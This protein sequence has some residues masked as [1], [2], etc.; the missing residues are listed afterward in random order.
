MQKRL[1]GLFSSKLLPQSNAIDTFL[2]FFFMLACL[3]ASGLINGWLLSSVASTSS[4]FKYLGR[5]IYLSSLL[6]LPILLSHRFSQIYGVTLYLGVAAFTAANWLHVFFYNAPLSAYVI[7]VLKETYIGEVYEFSREFFSAGLFIRITL[8]FLAP[9]PFLVLSLRRKQRSLTAGL[10]V[11]LAVCAFIAPRA[12]DKSIPTLIR[13]NYMA[14]FAISC[15]KTWQDAE[16]F[17][18]ALNAPVTL[19]QNITKEGTPGRIIVLVMGESSSRKH[20]SLYGYPRPTTPRLDALKSEFFVFSDVISPN[21]HTVPVLRKIFTFTE[22]ENTTCQ[23]PL[24]PTLKAG[25]YRVVVLSN[26]PFLGEYETETSKLLSLADQVRYFNIGHSGSKYSPANPDG[27]LLAPF[28]QNLAYQDDLFVI[29]HLMGSHS[30]YSRRVPEAMPRFEGAPPYSSLQHLND[31]RIQ[32]INDYDTSIAYT[33]IV[34]ADLINKLKQQKRPAALIY[35]SDHGEALYEDGEARGHAESV[36]C[37]YMYEVPFLLWLSE[38][39]KLDYSEF[40]GS[41]K[42]CVNR[43]WQSNN[44]AYSVFHLAGISFPGLDSS[45]DIL[46]PKFTPQERLICGQNYDVLFPNTPEEE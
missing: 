26:Q 35:L 2:A 10:I 8:A 42:N 14:D 45:R 19:P 41:I 38:E 34:L 37:R 9:L 46:S 11:L 13:W 33:D 25:G 20:Y 32:S 21:A 39:Y 28:T 3:A 43:P 7:L 36:S 31:A 6:A 30:A 22:S 29:L 17:N 24:I 27:V 44:L 23:L 5:E 12:V 4:A 18:A 40:A 1:S 15:A 16:S